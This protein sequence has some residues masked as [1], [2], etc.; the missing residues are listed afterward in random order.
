MKKSILLLTIALFVII[1]LIFKD[2]LIFSANEEKGLVKIHYVDNI[3]AAQE[4]IINSFN[5]ENAGK[6]EV[7]PVN[8]PFSKFT[9]NER[10]EILARSLRSKS[11]RMDVFAVDLIWGPRFAKWAFPLNT[12]FDGADLINF[13]GHTIESCRYQGKLIAIPFYTDV[14]LMYYRKDLLDEIGVTDSTLLESITWE[15]F[16]KLGKRFKNTPYPFFMFAGDN[17]EGMIC[18]FHESLPVK[19]SSEIAESVKKLTATT[20]SIQN[21]NNS[22]QKEMAETKGFIDQV[23]FYSLLAFI[24]F[25][26]A[27]MKGKD[28]RN[29]T[30]LSTGGN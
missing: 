16:I 4:K 3:S 20:L 21:M 25:M 5:T 19:N 30:V 6:I 1:I 11:E 27:R 22:L 15:D 26:G 18:S 2:T 13:W 9:T 23:I 14:G 8:L 28:K 24:L 10:K 29:T 12:Y 7:V 17:F